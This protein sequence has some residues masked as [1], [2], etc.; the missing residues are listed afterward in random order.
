MTIA[1]KK[2]DGFRKII[3]R[4]GTLALIGLMV[5]ALVALPHSLKVNAKSSWID[6][7]LALADDDGGDKGGDSG[8]DDGDSGG[9]DSDGDDSDS[10]GDD[11]DDGDDGGDGDDGDDDDGEDNDDS[12]DD[13]DDAAGHD[14]DDD[15]EGSGHTGDDSS[16]S[17]SADD[18][19]PNDGQRRLVGVG[20][21]Q[22]LSPVSSD[23]EEDL[24]GNWGTKD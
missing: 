15:H 14:G 5:L 7:S 6:S 1:P 12:D 18:D 10:D 13:S 4:L 22:G 24:V 19:S 20:G 2:R 3:D 17:G 8:G 16:S 21:V 9:D 23:D 11:G